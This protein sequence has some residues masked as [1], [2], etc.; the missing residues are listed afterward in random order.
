MS[1][2]NVSELVVSNNTGAGEIIHPFNARLLVSG[3]GST[4]PLSPNVEAGQKD[5]IFDLSKVQGLNNGD[6]FRVLASTESGARTPDELQFTY[7]KDSKTK[8]II[9]ILGAPNS[10]QIHFLDLTPIN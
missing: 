10:P 7:D 4:Y 8:A 2:G 3:N 5:I 6:N 1:I 9:V